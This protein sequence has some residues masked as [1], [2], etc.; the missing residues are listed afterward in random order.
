MGIDRSVALANM[1]DRVDVPE[2]R[3]VVAALAQAERL[4]SPISQTLEIQAQD[5]RLKR[6]QHAEEQ[7]MKLPVK[8]LFPM[9]FCILPVLLIII[10]APAVI[11]IFDALD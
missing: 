4:G 11:D 9:A 7:A 8:L 10:L 3:T 5:L 2:L 6:R 1:A